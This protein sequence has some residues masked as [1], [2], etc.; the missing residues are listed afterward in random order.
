M[1]FKLIT[2]LFLSMMVSC[3]S[4]SSSGNSVK[5]AQQNIQPTSLIGLWI[6]CTVINEGSSLD[7]YNF[8]SNGNLDVETQNFEN[9]SCSGEIQSNET[10]HAKYQITD[11]ST[12]SLKVAFT[13]ITL[14]PD[15][16]DTKT[17]AAN[18]TL[19]FE[20]NNFALAKTTFLQWQDQAGNTGELSQDELD[21]IP[22]IALSRAEI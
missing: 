16:S 1:L 12:D 6:S 10:M 22:E 3:N 2:F 8:Q 11:S 17:I 21:A 18:L 7:I 4:S 20:D 13:E 19:K 5:P 9:D 14:T 15:P